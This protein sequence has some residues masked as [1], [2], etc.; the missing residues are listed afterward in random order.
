MSQPVPQGPR[1][2]LDDEHRELVLHARPTARGDATAAAGPVDPESEIECRICRIRI[3][4]G[5]DERIIMSCGLRVRASDTVLVR[6]ARLRITP[7]SD[8]VVVTSGFPRAVLTERSFGGLVRFS[9]DAELDL[10]DLND[11]SGE[12]PHVNDRFEPF[13]VAGRI[14]ERGVFWDFR[15]IDGTLPGGADRLLFAANAPGDTEAAFEVNAFVSAKFLTGPEGSAR[16]SLLE[17]PPYVQAIELDGPN[18]R[19]SNFFA[20]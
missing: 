13:I 16:E 20:G 7:V 11:G 2:P 9:Q 15:S 10:T 5:D 18:G 12:V 4:S 6:W 19:R 17:M 14:A 1:F 8:G 3:V